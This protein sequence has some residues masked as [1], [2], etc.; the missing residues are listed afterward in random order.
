[1]N[2]ENSYLSVAMN[3][4]RYLNY[5]RNSGYNN[6]IAVQCQQICEKL[7]KSIVEVTV[8]KVIPALKSHD[9]KM[10]Y[11][12]IPESE[13]RSSVDR[14]KLSFLKDFYFSARYP[15]DNFVVVTDEDLQVCLDI[16][17]TLYTEVI[18]WHEEK[19]KEGREPNQLLKAAKASNV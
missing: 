17:D 16:T 7:L 10:I 14:F 12:A 13:F 5:V 3:D 4:Y 1:M 11:D 18:S 19:N 8:N 2:L 15:G 9:L 6:N